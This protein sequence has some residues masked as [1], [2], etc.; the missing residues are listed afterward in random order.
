MP[1]TLDLAGSEIEL[2]SLLNRER[3][4]LDAIPDQYLIDNGFD[5]L[6]ID[7]PPS[8]GLL[9]LNS[10]TAA[11]EVL[12]PIQCEFYALE[13]VTQLMNNV[14]MIRQHLNPELHISA[15]LLTMFD[16]RTKLSEEVANEVRNYFGEVVLRNLIPRSVKVSEAPGYSQTVISYDPGSRGAV[17]YLDAAKE[18]ATRGD[19]S[20]VPGG[21]AIGQK[22][23]SSPTPSNST[24]PN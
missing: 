12:I 3:R 17:A 1:A 7:C 4:L 11:N 2:V 22:P 8:L 14:Q 19:Y 20:A 18:L 24:E 16:G 9:T 15:V 10:M 5:F 6:I 23:A 13:G 21:S